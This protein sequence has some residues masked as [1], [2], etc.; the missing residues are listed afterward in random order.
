MYNLAGD[1]RIERMEP[2]EYDVYVS[3]RS[4]S[5]SD[6]AKLVSAGLA[7]RGFRVFFDRWVPGSAPAEGLLKIIEETPDFVLLLTPNSLD[8]CADEADRM[9]IEIAHALRTHRNIVP[10]FAPGYVQPP[11]SAL[12]PDVASF[13]TRQ[14]VSYTPRTKDESIA[15]IAHRLSSDATVDERHVMRE[16]TWIGSIAGLVLLA[17]I[18]ATVARV[19]PRMLARRIDTRPLPPLVLYWS[20]FGQRLD[21]GQWVEFAVQDGGRMVSGDQF[22]LVFSPSGDGFAYVL[23]KDLRGEISVLFPTRA[24]AA[25][26]RVRA[27]ELYQAPVGGGWVTVDRQAGVDTL[28]VVAS[29]DPIENLESLVEEHLEESSPQARQALLESTIA[30]LLDGRHAGVGMRVRTRHGRPIVGSPEARPSQPTASTV[31][32]GGVRVTHGLTAQPGLLSAVSEIRIQYER[33]P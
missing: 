12:P 10:V 27:G 11:P 16:A 5:G 24:L 8:Q 6:L 7:R 29:Y 21:N 15:R 20:G 19:V 17:V 14:A 31:L 33:A 3:Y 13:N 1:S 2:V 4:P 22:R 26:S 23:S 9:R 28:Y 32:A 30:G 18:A 25:E